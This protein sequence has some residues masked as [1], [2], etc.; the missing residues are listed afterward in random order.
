LL[1]CASVRPVVKIGL[2]APFEGRDR[3]I[4]YDAVYA[5][6]LAVREV[7]AAGGITGSGGRGGYRVALVALDDRGDAELATQT[8][9][10]L[11]VD[12]DVIA[13]VGHY[14]PQ[15]TAAAANVYANAGLPLLPAGAPPFAAADPTA[16]LPAFVAA[17]E[18]VTPFDETPG[19]YAGPTYDAFA[20]L[21]LALAQAEET[22]DGITRATVQEAL[23]GLEYEGMTGTVFQP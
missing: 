16:L 17:Y 2:V 22:G 3:A 6:R 23:R 8:A 18:G 19:P 5:A 15:T 1:G 13:V 10:A 4:G 7:N 21:W 9:A 11:V 14:L 12:A 20:L